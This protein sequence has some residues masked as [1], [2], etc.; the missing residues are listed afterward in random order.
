MKWDDIGFLVSKSKYNENSLIS[1]IYTRNHGKVTG[2]VFGG[3][4]KRIKNYL[5]IGNQL[6]VNYN[7]KSENSIGYFKLE[8]QNVFS[9]IYFDNRKKIT[10]IY[11][12]MNLVRLLTAE[13]Q[14]NINIFNLIEKF[15]HVISK[16]RWLK[17]YIF[18]ELELLKALGFD[19]ELNSLVTK[20]LTD[21]KTIYVV[22]ANNEKKIVPNFLID[23]NFQED[24]L[25]TLLKGLKLVSDFLEKNILQP[26]NLTYPISRTHFINSIK[27]SR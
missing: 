24:D 27:L 13:S 18:W 6:H 10:C 23:K 17:D 7:S 26:N 14:S 9:P 22:K 19:L 20:E 3:T 16:D 1:E 12:A 11:S 5:Q 21:N 8:I 25:N 4:S 15:Y 2:L